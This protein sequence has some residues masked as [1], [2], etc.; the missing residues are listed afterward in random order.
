MTKDEKKKVIFKDIE[1]NYPEFL[2]Q[3][4]SKLSRY[5]FRN[6]EHE[7]LVSEVLVDK[8]LNGYSYEELT[9]LYNCNLNTAKTWVRAAIH[10]IRKQLF[11]SDPKR[12][13]RARHRTA[14]EKL[15]E[16]GEW[17][18]KRKEDPKK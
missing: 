16:K 11:P 6:R 8:F 10:Y 7:D 4:K 3:A 18:P 1:N 2:R 17:P 13:D 14:K 15:R 9:E 12:V 5:N